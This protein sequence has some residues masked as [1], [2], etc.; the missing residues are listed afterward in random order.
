MIIKTD[1]TQKTQCVGS[2]TADIAGQFQFPGKK[3]PIYLFNFEALTEAG[4]VISNVLTGDQVTIPENDITKVK[5]L[6]GQVV[7]Y[8]KYDLIDV[9]TV[10]MAIMS[11]GIFEAFD[12][13]FAPVKL[14]GVHISGTTVEFAGDSMMYSHTNLFTKI[15]D[16]T[17]GI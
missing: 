8:E 4:L 6:S 7:S 5:T 15:S 9:G 12:S 1:I 17:F 14:T 13:A 10:V 16:G 11:T 2:F 3:G